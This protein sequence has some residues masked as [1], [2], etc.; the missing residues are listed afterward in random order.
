MR[1]GIDYHGVLNDNPF[2]KEMA[3]L[4]ME[5]GHRVY[6]VT[7]KS[8]LKVHAELEK[9]KIYRVVHYTEIFSVTDYLLE[10][11]ENVHWADENNPWFDDETWNS[12]KGEICHRENIDIHFDD[13]EEYAQYF[14][15]TAIFIKK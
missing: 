15:K 5:A 7:G 6:I 13:G 4:F 12:A 9:Q 10:K 2:F 1:I 14:G 11:G 8:K 3:R